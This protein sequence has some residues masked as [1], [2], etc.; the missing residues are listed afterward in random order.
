ME[1][2]KRL[3]WEASLLVGDCHFTG[4]NEWMNEIFILFSMNYYYKW[5]QVMSQ[6]N[7]TIGM[8]T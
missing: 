6:M 7:E 5:E 3:D 2:N 8:V 1:L 4:M